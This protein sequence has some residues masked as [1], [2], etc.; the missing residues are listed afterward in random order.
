MAPNPD[1][2]RELKRLIG[3]IDQRYPQLS[4]PFDP[5]WRSPCETGEPRPLAVPGTGADY[6]LKDELKDE[7]E[8]PWRPLPRPEKDMEW[9]FA[10]LERALEVTVHRDIKTYYATYYSG[11]LETDSSEG[12]VSLLQIWN[13][14]DAS[15]LIENLLGHALAQTRSKSPFSVFFALTEVDSEMF[16]TVENHTG[17][18]LLERPGYKPVRTVAQNLAEFLSGLSPAPPERHPERAAFLRAQGVN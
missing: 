5:D 2:A 10:P 16:L 9:L 17:H 7:L 18:V 8:V 12:P 3:E 6:V 4:D 11:G 15:R 13:D 14:E 1:V